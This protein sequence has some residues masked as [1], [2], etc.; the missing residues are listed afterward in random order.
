MPL[1][2]QTHLISFKVKFYG[3]KIIYI[4]RICCS[5]F[6]LLLSQPSHPLEWYSMNTF[7]VV[8]VWHRTYLT[9]TVNIII[10]YIYY[11]W[12]FV[13][14]TDFFFLNF[15]ANGINEKPNEKCVRFRLLSFACICFYLRCLIPFFLLR[16]SRTF[17]IVSIQTPYM[18]I[19]YF[20]WLNFE[21]H[22]V[23][24]N[25][26]TNYLTPSKRFI[27]HTFMQ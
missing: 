21:E 6:S 4:V 9:Y 12:H 3:R 27:H 15:S 22:K 17:C 13:R 19:E 2:W 23:V 5:G 25:W 20:P 24:L 10:K 8:T 26:I 11:L 18:N 1:E 16:A 14:Q 7:T